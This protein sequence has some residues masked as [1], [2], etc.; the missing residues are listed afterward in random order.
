[1]SP[2]RAM[3]MEDRNLRA[4]RSLAESS[5][6]RTSFPSCDHMQRSTQ[7]HMHV[8]KQCSIRSPRHGSRTQT[9]LLLHADPRARCTFNS[10]M[11][12]RIAAAKV[13]AAAGAS[14]GEDS[15]GGEEEEE[16]EDSD[17]DNSLGDD[18]LLADADS[19][20][21]ALPCFYCDLRKRCMPCDCVHSLLV[22]CSAIATLSQRWP[23][24]GFA[25]C[26]GCGR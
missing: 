10:S 14:E 13:Y 19:L 23:L 17:A 18:L 2:S 16:D 7:P 4:D 15:G 24:V 12:R 22:P 1:M 8:S 25:F 3:V 26:V 9:M 21:A 5:G 6:R 20:I 11:I